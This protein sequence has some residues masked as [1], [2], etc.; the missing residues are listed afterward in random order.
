MNPV[1]LFSLIIFCGTVQVWL[2]LVALSGVMPQANVLGTVVWPEWQ[3]MVRPERDALLFH[4]FV[5]IALS[6][7]AI[8]IW[9]VRHKLNHPSF[10]KTAMPFLTME[11][12]WTALMLNAGFK[13]I[14]YH[15]RPW[16]ARDAFIFLSAGALAS[17]VFWPELKG[18]GQRFYQKLMSWSFGY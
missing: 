14:V 4:C 17:K 1:V 18:W 11:L 15:D 16:L 13:I 3:Y 6:A 2:V 10:I 7:Q 8:G 12:V 5:G 9:L